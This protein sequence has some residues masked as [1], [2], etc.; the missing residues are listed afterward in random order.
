MA[1]KKKVPKKSD[2]KPP[3]SSTKDKAKKSEKSMAGDLG[4]PNVGQLKGISYGVPEFRMSRT[5]K[6]S[7]DQDKRAKTKSGKG[8]LK[9]AKSGLTFDSP[10]WLSKG[11]D[12][13]GGRTTQ[14]AKDQ[15]KRKKK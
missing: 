11:N 4:G 15:A 7:L 6:R 5:E 13:A 12:L 3:K 10:Y 8:Y 14:R 9:P 1:M 2:P